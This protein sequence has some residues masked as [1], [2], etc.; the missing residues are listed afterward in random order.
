MKTGDF[1][2]VTAIAAVFLLGSSCRQWGEIDPPAGNQVYPSLEKVSTLDFESDEGLDPSFRLVAHEGGNLP[3]IAEDEEKGK[4]LSLDGGYAVIE[5]PLKNVKL[6]K[7]ASMTFWIKQPLVEGVEKDV[8]SS[9][10]SFRKTETAEDTTTRT[11]EEV[12]VTGTLSV[13]EGQVKYDA[14]DGKWE[15]IHP[16]HALTQD[17]WH[18]VALA[19]KENGYDLHVDGELVFEKRPDSFDC[20]KLVNL[21]DLADEFVIGDPEN[22]EAAPLLIDD[23]TLYRNAISSKEIARPNIGSVGG[24][25]DPG[26]SGNWITV[27]PEDNVAPFWSVW[28]PYLNLTG[29]GTIHY[30]FYNYTAGNQNWENWVL[31]FTNGKERGAD[32]YAEYS[33]YRADAY[34]WGDKYNGDVIKHD[35]N[36]DTF[37][38]DMQGAFV[39]VDITRTGGSV[40]FTA[41]TN[42]EAGATYNYSAS[43]EGVDTEELGTFFTLENGH[44]VFNGD[45]TFVGKMYAPGTN[46]LG[47]TDYSTGWWSTWSEL[48]LFSVPFTNFGVEFTNHNNGTGGNWNNWLLICTNGKWIGEDGYAENFVLRSDAYGW[49]E[50]YEG[51]EMTQSFEW[52]TYVA[53]MSNS[54]HRVYFSCDGSKLTM[55][56]RA[57]K[58]DGSPFPE[59][60]FVTEVSSPVGLFFTVELA[61]L[62]ITKVGYFPW[63]DMNPQE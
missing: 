29:D 14:T 41:V 53:D 43:F 30:E 34:G 56:S 35:Y 21:A 49:G 51:G 8:T 12:D 22:A 6:Q 27:G 23:L 15:S 46:V 7:A 26:S 47:A 62:D 11:A 9:I 25:D 55:V 2:T 17:V 38:S 52:E 20:E 37:T 3:V 31:V 4:V 1:K 50:K 44:L 5:N 48:N 18:Y 58:T 40:E 13:S 36:W 10:L 45:A 63:V 16:T 28:S 33:V 42:T 60:R 59:Y 57:R 19:F 61:W 32:G 54:F 39:T 24:G